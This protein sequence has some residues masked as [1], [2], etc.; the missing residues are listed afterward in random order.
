MDLLRRQRDAVGLSLFSQQLD[1]HTS[2]RSSRVH[3]Q[4]LLHQLEQLIDTDK[5]KIAVR[6]S[7]AE[8]LHTIAER[9]HKRSLIIIFSD[10]MDDLW[11]WK[12][13]S[14]C[15]LIRCK[16]RKPIALNIFDVK[17]NLNSVVANI[18]LI[19]LRLIL[20]KVLIMFLHNI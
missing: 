9:S 16:F 18:R 15:D 10:M 1:L 20:I 6:T 7:A 2:A 12:Q 3:Q 17:T 5:A 4:Y 14:H 19:M 8:A 11:I 13:K